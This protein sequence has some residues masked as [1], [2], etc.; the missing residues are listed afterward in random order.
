MGSKP[1][2][3]STVLSGTKGKKTRP[4]S[5]RTVA[6]PSISMVKIAKKEM[7]KMC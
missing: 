7:G 3:W 4:K 1:M 2:K 6:V 5:G